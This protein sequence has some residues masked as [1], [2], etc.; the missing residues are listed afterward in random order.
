MSVEG[1]GDVNP[2][3][4]QQYIQDAQKNIQK[5]EQNLVAYQSEEDKDMKINRQAVMNSSMDLIQAALSEVK[6]SGI[7]KQGS[8]VES[9]YKDFIET[10]SDES[11]TKLNQDM[12][13]LKQYLTETGS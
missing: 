13:T 8:Q 4:E 10:N 12:A 6:R 5:F 2:I 1:A 3:K 11:L 9:D 7:Q